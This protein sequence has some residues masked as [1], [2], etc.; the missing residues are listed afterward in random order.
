MAASRPEL[1]RGR[2][3]RVF[4]HLWASV[5]PLGPEKRRGVR[6][7]DPFWFREPRHFGEGLVAD[8]IHEGATGA[9]GNAYEPYLQACARP[10]YLL[11]ADNQ[12]CNLAESYYLSLIYLSWQGVIVGDPLCALKP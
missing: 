3:F 2:H 1:F 10:D 5:L 9:S 12:G 4:Q 8:L 6:R 11:P 7:A